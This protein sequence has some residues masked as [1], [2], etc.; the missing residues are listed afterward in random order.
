MFHRG[1]KYSKDVVKCSTEVSNIPS[2]WSNIRQ[3]N[4]IF[5]GDA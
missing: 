2:R 5:Y 4:E 3:R 1:V